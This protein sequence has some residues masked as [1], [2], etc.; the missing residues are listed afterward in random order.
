VVRRVAGIQALVANFAN[1]NENLWLAR[2]HYCFDAVVL[3]LWASDPCRRG[4]ERGNRA[5]VAARQ[6]PGEKV[7]GERKKLGARAARAYAQAGNGTQVPAPARR[8]DRAGATTPF[9]PTAPASA[10]QRLRFSTL[11][12]LFVTWWFQRKRE[13]DIQQ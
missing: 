1:Y 3:S 11:L 10:R 8:R 12:L 13:R 2:R 5:R 6:E 7:P 9:M 4:D